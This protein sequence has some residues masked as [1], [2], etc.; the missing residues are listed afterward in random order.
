MDAR[1]TIAGALLVTAAWAVLAWVALADPEAASGVLAFFGLVMALATGA[2][3]SMR[4]RAARN[5]P[6]VGLE[7]V[8]PEAYRT[9]PP[10]RLTG[11]LEGYPSS[12][13]DWR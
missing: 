12:W 1:L 2:M 4:L 7:P 6:P 3:V 8:N 11:T 10:D 13:D 5:H 9:L